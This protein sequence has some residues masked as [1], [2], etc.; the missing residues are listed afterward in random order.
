MSYSS[1]Q[2]NKR[3]IIFQVFCGRWEQA[4]VT[5]HPG[6]V[7]QELAKYD[8]GALKATLQ[9]THVYL[10][11]VWQNSGPILVQKENDLDISKNKNRCP[12]PFAVS[13]HTLPNPLL[14]TN[15]EFRELIRLIHNSH[16]SVLVDFVPNHTGMTHPWVSEKPEYYKKNKNQ[17]I[18]TAFSG[19]VAELNYENETLCKEM[20]TVLEAVAAFGVDGVRADMAHLI[21]MFFWKDAIQQLRVTH[22]GF[23]FLAEA[24]GTSVFDLETQENL[25]DVGFDAIYDEPLYKNIKAYGNGGSLSDVMGHFNYVNKH[26]AHNWMHYVSNHDDTFPLDASKAEIWQAIVLLLP[27]WHLLYNGTLQGFEGRLAHHIIDIMVE[28]H[29]KPSTLSQ[30][31]KN[32]FEWI[33][34]ENPL[35]EVFEQV[36]EEEIVIHWRGVLH[37][38]VALFNLKLGVYEAKINGN[39]SR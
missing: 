29:T 26:R 39:N 7:F 37:S 4:N 21:P 8:W 6:K 14:G 18:Q 36:G 32:W 12:S 25:M 9:V 10:L 15:E 23:L 35:C 24:Y 16:L 22:P 1:I 33:G 2:L 38:G 30:T 31:L 20:N 13:Q 3:K 11:G 28:A 17:E 19:D 27:G 34:S 5:Q